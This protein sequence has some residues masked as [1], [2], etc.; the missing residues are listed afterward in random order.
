MEVVSA[1]SAIVGLAVPIFQC[2]KALRDRVKLVRYPAHPLCTLREF[3]IVFY[4]CSQ[5]ASEKVEL[6][7]ALT[8]YEKDIDLLESLYNGNKELLVQNNLDTDLKELAEY[9]CY[10]SS[11]ATGSDDAQ[12]HTRTRRLAELEQSKPG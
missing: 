12:N 9:V 10:S 7:E 4:P 3:I 5:V 11:F 2:A 8:E 6:L 1:A